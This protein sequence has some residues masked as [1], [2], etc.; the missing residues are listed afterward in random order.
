MGRCSAA[1]P[2]AATAARE[3][4]PLGA[5]GGRAQQPLRQQPQLRGKGGDWA[6]REAVRLVSVFLGEGEVGMG[7]C[8]AATPP[9]A[10]AAR[11]RGRLGAQGGRQIS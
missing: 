10:T 2:P 8:S 11:E 9:A 5:Q 4:G 7:R 3:G 1:T 6:R